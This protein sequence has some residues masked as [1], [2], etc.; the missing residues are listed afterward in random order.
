MGSRSCRRHSGGRRPFLVFTA[1]APTTATA[2]VIVRSIII[3]VIIVIIIV[4]MF[5][6]TLSML[7][8]AAAFFAPPI[9]SAES[10]GALVELIAAETSTVKSASPCR[11]FGCPA[12]KSRDCRNTHNGFNEPCHNCPS[13]TY[14]LPA[15]NISDGNFPVSFA[16]AVTSL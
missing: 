11:G 9:F 5:M 12:E 10:P 8:F 2:V 16:V 1:P 3:V 15:G 13:F 7:I 14:G 6:L 4:V